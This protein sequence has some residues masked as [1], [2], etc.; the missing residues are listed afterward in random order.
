MTKSPGCI[1]A[2]AFL[3][4]VSGIVAHPGQVEV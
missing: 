1:A 3:F 2:G 4:Q